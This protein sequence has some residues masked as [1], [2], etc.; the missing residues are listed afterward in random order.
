MLIEEKIEDIVFGKDNEMIKKVISIFPTE[1]LEDLEVGGNW[2][3]LEY[4]VRE[5]N[6]E[7]VDFLIQKGCNIHRLDKEK[8][9]LFYA[10]CSSN[11]ENMELFQY[12]LEKGV[13]VHHISESG[14]TPFIWTAY[15][16]KWK[17]AS[18][19]IK[20]GVDT[21]HRTESGKT[22]GIHLSEKGDTKWISYFLDIENL[23]TPEETKMLKAKRIELMMK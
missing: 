10:I 21:S 8:D 15:F 23:F 19:M 14:A 12:L 7:I 3:I 1:V 13:D 11:Y 17:F 16:R 5:G 4:Y 2:S 9:N 20:E 18:K 22:F 6:L